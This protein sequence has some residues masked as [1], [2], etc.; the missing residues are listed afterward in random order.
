MASTL[1]GLVALDLRALAAL[2]I[3]LGG[4][5]LVDLAYRALDL[6]A[7]YTDV[8]VLPR[9]ALPILK[10][11]PETAWSLH[12]LGGGP[13][14]QGLLFG[15]AALAAIAL[16]LGYRTRLATA[17]SWG[18]LLSLHHRNPLVLIGADLM[19]RILLF[20]LLLLPAGA[21]W[22][23]DRRAG[24]VAG[25][26]PGSVASLASAGLVLQLV[27]VYLFSVLF[28]LA[29]PTWRELSALQRTLEVE[30]VAT[31]LGRML[32]GAPELLAA[33][34]AATLALEAAAVVGLLA[35]WG[36]G[37]VRLALA[38]VM[39]AF[40]GLGLGTTLRLG[41][42][43]WVMALAW[44]P[45][46]PPAFWDRFSTPGEG[47]EAPTG[48]PW[49]LPRETLAGLGLLLVVAD[50][51][52]SLDRE[53]WQ[54]RAPRAFEAAVGALGLGQG[55][56]L[57]DRPLPNRYYVFPARLADGSEVDLHRGAP[58]DWERPRRRS[59]NNHW[60]K[61]QLHLSRVYGE[62]LRPH[63]ARQLVWRWDRDR[64]PERRVESLELV[65]VDARAAAP[66]GPLPRRRLWAGSAASLR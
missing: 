51:L 53:R 57:W 23:L 55:W 39:M 66:P 45:L 24:R 28:K 16:A 58:L 38:V 41:L 50:N 54:P 30:G 13:A 49:A 29:E 18:L 20:W 65:Y 21:R 19:L 34:T 60:W 9:A 4:A 64:P 36:A 6:E 46:L 15:V 5:L 2:R 62:P 32:L 27:A 44:V 37:R 33:L 31:G 43:P 12:A 52:V 17:L 3:G 48:W 11:T 8:G 56:H 40:H 22:S 26:G 63:Y 10:A 1:R 47:R 35:P 25:P 14:W 7:H 42:F 61:Y 59:R